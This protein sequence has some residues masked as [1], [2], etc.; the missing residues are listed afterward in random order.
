MMTAPVEQV[1]P[2]YT[3]IARWA[4]KVEGKRVN[5]VARGF[6]RNSVL[7]VFTDGT[8]ACLDPAEVEALR[9]A[10]EVAP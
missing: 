7:I 9:E 5:S 4:A 3:E 2:D 10:A 6:W 1:K 8:F